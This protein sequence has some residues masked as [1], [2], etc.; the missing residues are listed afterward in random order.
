MIPVAYKHILY[1]LVQEPEAQW[2]PLPDS[3]TN[4]PWFSL[5]TSFGEKNT[6]NV[7][8]H[9]TREQIITEPAVEVVEN[10]SIQPCNSLGDSFGD[11]TPQNSMTETTG[12]ASPTEPVEI[13]L[14]QETD[15]VNVVAPV[16]ESPRT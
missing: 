10:I 6:Q 13:L 2:E 9:Q 1:V 14:Q 12:Q 7:A 5:D 11:W 15:L 16:T 4:Q 8:T 3:F